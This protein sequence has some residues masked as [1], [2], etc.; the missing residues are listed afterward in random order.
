MGGTEEPVVSDFD[1]AFRKNMLKESAN[2]L[3]SG[4]SGA[5]GLTGVGILVFKSNLVILDIEDAFIGKGNPVDIRSKVFEG[6]FAIADLF[7]VDAPILLPNLFFDLVKERGFFE[8]ICEL[9]AEYSGESFGG[10]Q[11]VLGGGEPFFAIF[12]DATPRDEIM[13]MR[14]VRE[15]ARPGMEDPHHPNETADESGIFGELEQSLRGGFEK[16]VVEEFL[17]G[18]GQVSEFTGK[19]EGD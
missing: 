6:V 19:S 16:E 17:V 15:I 4:K 10:D 1:K 5:F 8:F 18:T 13:E 11:E 7:R 14:V 2:E 3:E 9:S 12:R